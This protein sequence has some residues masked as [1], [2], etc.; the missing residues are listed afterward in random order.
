MAEKTVGK[1]GL[2][3]A[4]RRYWDAHPIGT[5]DAPHELG[6]RAQFEAIYREWQQ[7]GTPER[8]EFL[9]SC[10][11]GKVLEVGCGIAKDGRF[12]SENGIDY[13]AV[14]LSFE[15]LK[16][17]TKHF[18]QNGLPS[19]FANAD[20]TR[21]PFGDAVFDLVFS[22]GVLHHVPNTAAACRDVARVLRPGG[23]L[24]IMMYERY[25]YHY[26]LVSFVVYP[27]I[28]LFVTFPF[29]KGLAGLGPKKLQHLSE[30][31]VAH[32]LTKKRLLSASTDTS[33][34]GTDNFNPHSSFYCEAELRE[35]F[36]GFEDFTFC[37]TDLRYFPFPWCRSFFE[38]RC[39][40]FLHMTA[41]KCD[42]SQ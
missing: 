21:L 24:R 22:I 32:G 25:S 42:D 11:N 12:L 23:I 7:H 20:A 3:D 36:D 9:E 14:D 33:S 5:D 15:S 17:A 19:R 40:F 34:T 2:E 26:F 41:R 13:Q 1:A 28:W 10:R 6:S 18:R 29:L 16:L 35:L 39:G 31:S 27:L 38:R 30:I 8:Q 4:V 37:K